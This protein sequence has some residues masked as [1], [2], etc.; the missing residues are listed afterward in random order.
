MFKKSKKRNEFSRLI[1]DTLANHKELLTHSRPLNAAFLKSI[2]MK[3]DLL[4]D[5][6]ELQDKV[7]TVYH[8]TMHT[9]AGTPAA[10]IIENHNGR[11]Y[12][13]QLQQVIVPQVPQQNPSPPLI[14]RGNNPPKTQ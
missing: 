14:P 12:I 10:K 7:L 8:A 6:P 9:L 4:E 5:D 2:H 13:K 1:A 11:A 3:I